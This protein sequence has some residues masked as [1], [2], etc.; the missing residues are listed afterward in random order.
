MRENLQDAVS[1]AMGRMHA[2]LNPD[3][4]AKLAHLI[5]TGAL[6]V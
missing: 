4:R 1:R 5:R 3:Q 6:S 2:I